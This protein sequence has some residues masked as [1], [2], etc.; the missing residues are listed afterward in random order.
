MSS[1]V[2]N[3]HVMNSKLRNGFFPTAF[4]FALLASVV[5]A[6]TVF[7]ANVKWHGY[8]EGMAI[9]KEE[10]K[11][12]FMFFWAEWCKFCE[13]MEA[14]TL[15]EPEIVTYLNENFVSIKVESDANKQLA[16]RYF[17]RG[18]P[19]LWFLGENGEKISSLPGFVSKA[20]LLPL[21][22]YVQSNSYKKMN[23]NDFKEKVVGST[24]AQ[25]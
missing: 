17:V 5:F 7:S 11:K 13:T 24:K 18:L 6:G 21:L 20:Q 15:S 10:N 23:F 1:F 16:N 2:F 3:G 25:P 4:L 12:V 9:G 8:D 14:Q 22:R 19:T